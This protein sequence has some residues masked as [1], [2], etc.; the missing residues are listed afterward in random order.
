VYDREGTRD[1]GP[2][3]MPKLFR[4][5]AA[6]HAALGN[7]APATTANYLTTHTTRDWWY[8][9]SEFLEQGPAASEPHRLAEIIQDQRLSKRPDQLVFNE[10]ASRVMGA[11]GGPLGGWGTQT[12]PRNAR[13]RRRNR[14]LVRFE[15]TAEALGRQNH[16]RL[17]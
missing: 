16:R 3:T 1:Y 9:T 10:E 17:P 15:A 8:P 4:R 2:V 7:A 13:V 6:C 5:L 11:D 12:G 14:N